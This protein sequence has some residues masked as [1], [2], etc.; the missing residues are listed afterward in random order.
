MKRLW[1]IILVL[2]ASL[3]P[4]LTIRTLSLRS[5][6]ISTAA[7][8]SIAVDSASASKR[9][10]AAI[11]FRTVAPPQGQAEAFSV[12]HE[13]LQ[14][15]FPLLHATLAREK[16]A[17]HSLLYIWQGSNPALNPILLLAH[18]DVVPADETS[19]SRWTHPP[20]SGVVANGYVWG[21]GTMDDKSSL[22]AMLEAVEALLK[23]GFQP[24]R[25]IYFAFGHYEEIGGHNGAAAIAARLKARGLEFEFILDEG[26]NITDGIIPNT[27]RPVALIGIAEKGYLSLE[28]TV[29]GSGGHSSAPPARTPIGILSSA[30]DRLERQPM[31]TRITLP[32]EQMFE[33]L[34][35]EMAWPQT[36]ILA[37]L[38]LFS[39]LVQRQLAQSPLTNT[40]VRT[41]QAATVFRGGLSENVLADHARAVMNYRI[42][43]GDSIGSV[44][45]HV[46]HVV[47][48]PNVKIAPFKTQAEPSAISNPAAPGLTLIQRSLK[49]VAPDVLF[50]PALLVAT[51]DSRH[52]ASLSRNIYRFVP[53]RLKPDDAQRYHGVDER[54]ALEDYERCI[55][56]YAQLI[57]NSQV[58]IDSTRQG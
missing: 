18:Q 19:A 41:T 6:Q 12:L 35:P 42:L 34:A 49:Q 47:A 1:L 13:L 15:S 57:K 27:D 25:S 43:P 4:I 7:T 9:L 39:P 36:M 52:Y 5:R 32:T 54:I 8:E 16:I 31:P 23:S 51:T 22:L 40:I 55:K 44:I 20:F 45:D 11:Q 30:I 28:L 48:D 56:F 58:G 26:L 33:F 50:A 53:I 24:A 14:K 29:S 38:W 21:R 3:S 10:S 2:A 17:E 46:R 37:N